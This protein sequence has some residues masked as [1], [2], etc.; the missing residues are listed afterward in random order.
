MEDV[1]S[2]DRQVGLG[3]RFG[4]EVGGGDVALAIVP[5]AHLVAPGRQ[6]AGATEVAPTGHAA[7]VTRSRTLRTAL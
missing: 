2:F 3:V 5:V 4:R 6:L 7:I 1:G